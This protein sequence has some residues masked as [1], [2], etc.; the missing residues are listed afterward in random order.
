M[1][2][3]NIQRVNIFW[4]RCYQWCSCS[5]WIW[6]YHGDICIWLQQS[7]SNILFICSLLFISILGTWDSVFEIIILLGGC[8]AHQF[9]MEF[10]NPCLLLAIFGDIRYPPAIKR[11]NWKSPINR[12]F[13]GNI[14]HKPRIFEC[15]ILSYITMFCFPKRNQFNT[16][17][18]HGPF[19]V[20]LPIKIGDFP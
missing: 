15:H 1:A 19:I 10:W 5:S 6:R 7:E 20:D 18:E 8:V 14:I 11:G 17:I 12:G 4:N 16:A 13:Y 2:M 9:L 3:L